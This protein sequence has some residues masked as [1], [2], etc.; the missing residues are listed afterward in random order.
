MPFI[1]GN[2]TLTIDGVD[3]QDEVSGAVFTPTSSVVTRK[4]LSPDA[5]F[6]FPTN[7]TWTLDLTFAQDFTADTTL[8]MYLLEHEGETITDVVFAPVS[9]GRTF[10]ADITIAPGAIGGNVDEVA[11][12]T[13]S[14]GST[15]PVP[16]TLTP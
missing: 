14:L 3:Y 5:V 15:K 4:G 13:V 6:S 9:G 16:S 8:A 11:V 2:A 12:G 7:A 1:M 10:T